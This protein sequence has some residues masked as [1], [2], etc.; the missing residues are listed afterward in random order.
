MQTK[1]GVTGGF[2][3][4]EFRNPPALKIRRNMGGLGDLPKIHPTPPG[5]WGVFNKF[6]SFTLAKNINS[7]YTALHL[8]DS[9]FQQC[10]LL[11][12][13][14]IYTSATVLLF[15]PAATNIRSPAGAQAAGLTSPAQ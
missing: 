9:F 1:G 14:P 15:A 13:D 2:G 6:H 3:G 11:R 10:N 8:Q 4:G 7:S 5:G 12:P